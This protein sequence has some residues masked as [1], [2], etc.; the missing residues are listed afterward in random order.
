MPYASSVRHCIVGIDSEPTPRLLLLQT[1][2]PQTLL[3]ALSGLQIGSCPAYPH[4]RSRYPPTNSSKSSREKTIPGF[5]LSFLR[6]SRS[7]RRRE[8]VGKETALSALRC[9]RGLH[10]P[11]QR[12]CKGALG[13]LVDVVNVQ[14]NSLAPN[15]M[16]RPGKTC[17]YLAHTQHRVTLCAA[18]AAAT[19]VE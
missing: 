3:L 17:R 11:L 6:P 1:L 16:G 13:G 10:A 12:C 18:A 4:H 8:G 7:C 15:G 2:L 5:R 19:V 9:I 14:R